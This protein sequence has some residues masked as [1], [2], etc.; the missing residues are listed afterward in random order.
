MHIVNINKGGN[1]LNIISKNLDF[2]TTQF[3]IDPSNKDQKNLINKLAH[4]L[5]IKTMGL[6]VIECKYP[7]GRR[8]KR[9]ETICLNDDCLTIFKICNSKKA[10]KEIIDLDNIIKDISTHCSIKIKGILLISENY[11]NSTLL[12]LT[13]LVSCDITIK[14]YYNFI[15]N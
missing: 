10:D 9:L 12:N 7:F 1:L 3:I 8:D 11:N 4:S 13:N 2:K 15:D 6:I 14:E 5:E